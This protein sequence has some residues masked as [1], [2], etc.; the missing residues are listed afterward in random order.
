MVFGT[1]DKSI[2]KLNSYVLSHLLI[3]FLVNDETL[4]HA[5]KKWLV[6]D[7]A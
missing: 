6:N 2:L 1:D 5:S 3:I 7:C 4:G